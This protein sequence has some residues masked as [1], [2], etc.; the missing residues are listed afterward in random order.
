[1]AQVRKKPVMREKSTQTLM[2]AADAPT[3]F[4]RAGAGALAGCGLLGVA[5]AAGLPTEAPG[6]SWAERAPCGFPGAPACTGSRVLSTPACLLT[7]GICEVSP[8]AAFA[9]AAM[10]SSRAAAMS[11]RSVPACFARFR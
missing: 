11:V 9:I 10:R 4:V 7:M 1:M 3:D 2:S 5:A 8:G 6:A